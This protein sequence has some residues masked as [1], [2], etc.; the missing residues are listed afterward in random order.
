[1][2]GNVTDREGKVLI[3]GRAEGEIVEGNCGCRTC[4]GS[5]SVLG[6]MIDVYE[7]TGG[8]EAI[9]VVRVGKEEGLVK[10]KGEE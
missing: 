9:V 1:M 10:P 8:I 4:F 7:E 3:R 6:I 2:S 5:R